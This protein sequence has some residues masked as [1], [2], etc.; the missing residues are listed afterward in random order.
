[1]TRNMYLAF[2]PNVQR[3]DASVVKAM[4][5]CIMDLR[6]WIIKDRLMFNDDKAEFLLLGT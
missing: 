6:K 1:M 3:N 4:C 5:D 2:N